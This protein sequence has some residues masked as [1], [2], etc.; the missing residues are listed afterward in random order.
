MTIAATT[1]AESPEDEV[2]RRRAERHAALQDGTRRPS[3][4]RSD[5]ESMRLLLGRC[6]SLFRSLMH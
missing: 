3:A 4:R 5:T 1:Q 6:R 2:V